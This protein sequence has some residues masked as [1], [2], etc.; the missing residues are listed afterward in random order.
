MLAG[1]LGGLV[2]LGG[3]SYLTKPD[4]NLNIAPPSSSFV[5]NKGV[6]SFPADFRTAAHKSM[7]AVVHI[8]SSAAPRQRAPIDN[9]FSFFFG[10]S[11]FMD[12]GPQVGTGSGVIYSE[13]GFIITNNHVIDFADEI[14]VTLYDNR[15][16]KASIIGRDEKTD[17]AILKIEASDLPTI[18]IGNS[19]DAQV[20]D[21]VL[22]VGNPF[23][24]TS[25]VTAGIVSAKGRSL[26]M[27]GHNGKIESFIQTDA[28][29][30]PGNSG[31]ALVNTNGELIGINTAI[32]SLTGS[33][34]GYSFAIPVNIVTTVA[35]NLIQFGSVKRG[36]LGI[37][38]ADM[39]SELSKE[40]MIKITQG[41]Y[42]SELI[43]GGSAQMAGVL[44]DD[45]IV[46][47]NNHEIRNVPDL[48]SIIGESNVG[49]KLKLKIN[50]RGKIKE[51]E[52][53]LKG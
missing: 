37:M 12:F 23:E 21:W 4:P 46:A 13:D 51:I 34:A 53:K 50:R 41:A 18:Q 6:N 47:V 31:G 26:D 10:E 45:V 36:S 42:V 7:A 35:D 30:N 17:L 20:G 28:V 19:D 8:K 1:I 43:Q 5:T 25:T 40:L 11:P 52:V 2:V 22:A 49:D 15:T 16:Y 39:D 3:F 38:I 9:P 27:I 44:P 33:Y 29:V 24:L 32:A 48:M 14:E